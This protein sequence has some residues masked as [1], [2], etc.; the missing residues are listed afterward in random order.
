MSSPREEK[1][2]RHWFLSYFAKALC[3]ASP[4]IFPRSRWTGSDLTLDA[5]GLLDGI[6]GL[7]TAAFTKFV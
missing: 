6:H 4:K 1:A 2:V 5:L 3:G 7:G